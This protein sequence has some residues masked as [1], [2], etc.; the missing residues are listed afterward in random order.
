MSILNYSAFCFCLWILQDAKKELQ[1]VKRFKE[2]APRTRFNIL[3]SEQLFP[4]FQHSWA[5]FPPLPRPAPSQHDESE[6]LQTMMRRM[7]WVQHVAY[8]S[9]F[10]LF[11]IFYWTDR[12]KIYS[13]H[14]MN[15]GEQHFF[16]PP[17]FYQR[18]LCL[19]IGTHNFKLS[20]FY[21]HSLIFLE[22]TN[23]D[24]TD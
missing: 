4:L 5:S 15:V 12:T 14:L 11:F 8:M 24:Q 17:N 1:D 10:F 22:M 13:P 19:P 7:V 6:D 21:W 18:N 20:F 3:T 2:H 9:T 23:C 16:S